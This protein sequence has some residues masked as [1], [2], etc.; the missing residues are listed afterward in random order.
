MNLD[1]L[2]QMA[3][4]IGQFF[5]AMP[6]RDEAVD[7]VAT[8]LKRYWEPRMRELLL[9]RTAEGP[10]DGLHPLVAA[11]LATRREA[12]LPAARRLQPSR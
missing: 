6:D 12:L 9:A 4:A 8:H 2:V 5:D 3:N 11:A 10:I 7:G 1:T